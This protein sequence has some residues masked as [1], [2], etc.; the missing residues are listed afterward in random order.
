MGGPTELIFNFLID[1]IDL[2][3]KFY[4]KFGDD[5]LILKGE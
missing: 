5:Y 3:F 4:I 2:I 1:L